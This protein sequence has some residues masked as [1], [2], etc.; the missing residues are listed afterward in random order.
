[1]ETK[2]IDLK[3]PLVLATAS[4]ARRALVS[5]TGLDFTA[6]AVD[7]DESPLPGEAISEYVERLSRAKADAVLPPSLD[8]L[9]VA[10]D[11]AIGLGDEII[12][13]PK[14]AAHARKILTKLSAQTHEVASAIALRD[15]M[16]ASVSVEVTRT[17]VSFERL[18]EKTI[19]WY[20][21]TGEWKNRAGAYA[22]QG[23]GA[24]LIS[25]VQGCFTNV[26]GIS[27]PTLV[28]MLLSV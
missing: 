4:E 19:E 9:I 25:R 17:E 20:I 10:V 23:K 7:I 12:G 21:S 28:R 5:A 6:S 15:I 2:L 13:K 14:D 11:T 27:I 22:I 24:A 26:I 18:P 16:A 1:M 3:R 8:A